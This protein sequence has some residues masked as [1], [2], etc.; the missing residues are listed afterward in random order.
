MTH[1][2]Q[3][4]SKRSRD[5]AGE[6]AQEEKKPL[7]PVITGKVIQKKPSLGSKFKTV[8]FGGEFRSAAHY[9]V[10]DVLLPAFR[11][12]LVDGVTKG[13]E[14]VVYG[15]SPRSPRRPG[16]QSYGGRVQYS[17]PISQRPATLP[18]RLP[19]QPLRQMRREPNDLVLSSRQEAETVLERLVDVI[20]QYG[21]A[22]LADLYELTGLPASPIDNKWGWTYLRNAEVRQIR[23]GYLLDLPPVEEI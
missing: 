2:Y 3:G 4:N 18:A 17:S 9:V 15:D 7:E 11:N 14:R 1:D 8:V 5:Q 6:K 19:D 21:T 10:G 23:E 22:S 16:F 13:M 12:L 20:D